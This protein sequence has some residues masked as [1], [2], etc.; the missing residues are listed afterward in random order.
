MKTIQKI[1]FIILL[2]PLTVESDGVNGS[3]KTHHAMMMQRDIKLIS[4][5]ILGLY[6][7]L[8]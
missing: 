1:R 3:N 7:Q 2:G 5:L 8:Q 4:H 6:S